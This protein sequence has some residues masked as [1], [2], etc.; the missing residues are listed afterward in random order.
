M[1]T[2]VTSVVACLLLVASF[3]T[4]AYAQNEPSPTPPVIDLAVPAQYSLALCTTP[5]QLDCIQSV[6]IQLSSGEFV[7]VALDRPQM[8]TPMVDDLGNTR[9]AGSSYF[10]LPAMDTQAGSFG[11]NAQIETP[12]W[13]WR[14][15]NLTSPGTLAVSV[16]NL[17][18]GQVSQVSIR[19]GSWL[20]PQNLQFKAN[21]ANY[22]HSAIAG[23]NLWTFTG[24]HAR[25]SNYNSFQSDWSKKADVDYLAIQF[26]VHNAGVNGGRS[27]WDPRCAHTGFMAQAFNAPGAGSPEWDRGSQS[28]SFNIGAPHLDSQGNP[29]LGFFRLW[30]PEAF[31]E[32]QWPD[33]TLVDAPALVGTIYNED[34]SVQ[35]A[36]IT[37]TKQN[38]MIFLDAKNFH[39][40]A[41]T[42]QISAAGK[43][44]S[45]PVIK[46]TAKPSASSSSKPS[47]SASERS[48]GDSE[49][50]KSTQLAAEETN[51]KETD[52]GTL[53]GV[54]A[55]VLLGAGLGATAY[56]R[57]KQGKPL[58]PMK[59][60]PSV[61][62]EAKPKKKT[63]K[64]KS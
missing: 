54:G 60:N 64:T 56:I 43:K 10:T 19:T 6:K 40:S 33:N 37:V 29:N 14:D 42:F 38:G 39:Y 26:T 61:S 1:K 4:V 44:I 51:T 53:I 48:R 13:R 49:K 62:K 24:T 23:G 36:D 20:R 8:W 58:F 41:P 3:T 7:D 52:S 2:K 57:H 11:V 17:P 55:L 22:T 21:L 32:C 25:Q 50:I 47:P 16:D 27:F 12:A 34:G 59:K 35:D 18:V 45:P 31:A 15:S 9:Y 5:E 63:A 28:L 46:S 30:L